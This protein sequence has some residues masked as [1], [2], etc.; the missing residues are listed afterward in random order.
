[1]KVHPIVGDRVTT[2]ECITVD[3][4]GSKEKQVGKLM[5][6]IGSCYSVQW[7]E[8][9]VLRGGYSFVAEDLLFVLLKKGDPRWNIQNTILSTGTKDIVGTGS[10]PTT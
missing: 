8:P 10:L 6:K 5:F 2:N 7:L 3:T 9:K 4:Q 1:M